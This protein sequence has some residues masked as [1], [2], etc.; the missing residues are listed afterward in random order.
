[1]LHQLLFNHVQA[2][3]GRLGFD[4]LHLVVIDVFKFSSTTLNNF[5]SVGVT[6][7]IAHGLGFHIESD[8]ILLEWNC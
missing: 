7:L 3:E 8:F 1:M 5:L 6:D 4:V 2:A